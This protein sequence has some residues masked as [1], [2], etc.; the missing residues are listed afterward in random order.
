MVAL[1]LR[2]SDALAAVADALSRRRRDFERAIA[3]RFPAL[4][5]ADV[6]QRA[7][8][9]AL[10]RAGEL[11]DPARAEAWVRRI[12]VTCA[13]D[14]ARAHN[15]AREIATAELPAASAPARAADAPCQCAV[16][17]LTSLPTPYADILRR[18]DVDGA[19]LDDASSALGIT[20]GN[21]AVRLHRARR[22]LRQRMADHCGVRSSR[23]CVDCICNERGCCPPVP[24]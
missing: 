1:A 13:L 3:R 8:V 6:Y 17:L 5:A 15:G 21:A 22:A 12:V 11:R 10:E 4:D 23:D 20:K 18:V 24:S 7:A 2:Q 16:A 9:R 19:T 14:R